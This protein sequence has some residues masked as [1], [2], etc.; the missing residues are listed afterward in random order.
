M[1]DKWEI[2]HLNLIFTV[3]NNVLNYENKL[4]QIILKTKYHSHFSNMYIFRPKYFHKYCFLSLFRVQTFSKY[5]YEIN[6]LTSFSFFMILLKVLTNLKHFTYSKH[7]KFHLI[8]L[9][10]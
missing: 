3:D 4:E 7:F 5:L 8:S 1:I 2:K 6:F 10:M 9:R